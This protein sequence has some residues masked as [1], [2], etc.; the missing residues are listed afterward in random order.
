VYT[1]KLVN[2]YGNCVDSVSRTITIGPKPLVDFSSVNSASCKAPFTVDF[3]N[4]TPNSTAW[5]W[6]FGDGTTSTEK[7]PRHTYNQLGQYDITLTATFGGGCQN[8]VTKPVF[9]KVVEPV[10]G[11]S[12]LPAGGCIPY[13]FTPKESVKAVDGVASWLWDFGDGSTSTQRNP[14]HV[15][16]TQGNFDIKLRIVTTTGCVKDTVFKDGVKTGAPITVDFSADKFQVCASQAVQFTDLSTGADEWLWDFGDGNSSDLRNPS[17]IFG[18]T[19]YVTVT[20]TAFNNRCA[21]AVVKTRYIHVDPPVA[22]FAYTVDCFNK[23]LVSFRDSSIIDPALGNV[24]YSWTFGNGLGATLSAAALA[25]VIA[26][27]LGLLLCLLR[28]SD[29]KLI[30]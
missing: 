17:H 24:S 10:I 4:Q 3:T 27:P 26:F 19:G 14:S 16:T 23:R 13:T 7:N 6:N 22:R 5:F 25:A 9:V 12:N 28:I 29:V 1:V 15:Y 11:V 21:T 30:R 20:L 8:M 18:D 2:R